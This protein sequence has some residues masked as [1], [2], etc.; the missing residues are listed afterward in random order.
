M[1]NLVTIQVQLDPED[2][3][4]QDTTGDPDAT[5]TDELEDVPCA[6]VS[7]TGRAFLAA[8]QI[9][10]EVTHILSMRYLAGFTPVRHRL[11]LDGRVLEILSVIDVEER[12]REMQVHC[13]ELAGA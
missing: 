7:Q 11:T 6:V 9:N 8:Q 13:K 5:W 12:H 4:N 3:A 10:N 1:R 2:A